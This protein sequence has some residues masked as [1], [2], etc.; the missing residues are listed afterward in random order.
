MPTETLGVW[1]G[2]IE[3]LPHIFSFVHFDL[4]WPFFEP[5]EMAYW[6]NSQDLTGGVLAKLVRLG[7]SKSRLAGQVGCLVFESNL[8]E[9]RQCALLLGAGA[10]GWLAHKFS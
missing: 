1:E 4:G 2:S 10:L 7:L 5:F 6:K 8:I 9:G 3:P